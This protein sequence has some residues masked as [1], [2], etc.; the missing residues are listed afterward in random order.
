[1]FQIFS[2][3]WKHIHWFHDVDSVWLV[4]TGNQSFIS[5]QNGAIM[6][7]YCSTMSQ[8]SPSQCNTASNNP[9]CSF[10]FIKMNYRLIVIMVVIFMWTSEKPSQKSNPDITVIWVSDWFKWVDLFKILGL[11]S[12]FS[13]NKRTL[14]E[15][16][17]FLLAVFN[18]CSH[19]NSSFSFNY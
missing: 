17:C 2:Y 10:N 16:C 7:Q 18:D 5:Y 14:S 6:M 12:Q 4:A 3:Y 15:F 11:M 8:H 9:L 1:M 13:T 19:A